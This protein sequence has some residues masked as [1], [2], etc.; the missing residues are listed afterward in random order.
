MGSSV[1]F[2]PAAATYEATRGFPP[3]IAAQV[4]VAAVEWIGPVPPGHWVLEVGVGTGRI[5]RPL[6]AAGLPMLGVDLS[7]N[8]LAELRRL[9]VPGVQQPVVLRGDATRLPLRPASCAAAVG[10][11]IFHLIP[12][13]EQALA[14]IQRVLTPGGALFF[15]YD[16]RDEESPPAQMMRAWRALLKEQGVSKEHPGAADF[17]QVDRYLAERGIEP[18]ERTVA[19]WISRRTVRDLIAGFENRTWSSTWA[20]PDATFASCLAALRVWTSRELGPDDAVVE[21]PVEFR[22]QR[23]A[24]GTP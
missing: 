5:A 9:S 15:G 22:W 2:D 3:G 12:E 21:V 8:M 20:I 16:H 19:E 10:V 4:A 7:D 14:E 23:Y 17:N 13:W 6:A 24:L 11:H 18:T 1:N